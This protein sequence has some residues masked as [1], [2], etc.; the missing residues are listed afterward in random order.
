MALHAIKTSSFILQLSKQVKE[1]L[2]GLSKPNQLC[3]DLQFSV[4][5][6]Q[7]DLYSTLICSQT[8]ENMPQKSTLPTLK[9]FQHNASGIL[10]YSFFRSFK[11]IG[12]SYMCYSHA[13]LYMKMIQFLQYILICLHKFFPF[14]LLC[15]YL[16][17]LSDLENKSQNNI[18]KK[19][20]V[21]HPAQSST[22]ED[23]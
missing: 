19:Y 2:D 21:P 16:Y 6:F 3:S 1:K 7:I 22:L 13:L 15:L 4:H 9:L 18:F 8:I 11:T 12:S 14:S 17:V 20:L 10:Q 5:L 23:M